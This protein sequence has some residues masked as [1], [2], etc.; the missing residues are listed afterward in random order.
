MDIFWACFLHD[1]A[2]QSVNGTYVER[3]WCGKFSATRLVVELGHKGVVVVEVANYQNDVMVAQI[4]WWREE[5]VQ[6]ILAWGNM[7]D[8]VDVI[9][10]VLVPCLLLCCGAG[11]VATRCL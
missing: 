2:S 5:S 3:K 4:A 6:V 1:T 9:I 7:V 8:M 11:F 10:R